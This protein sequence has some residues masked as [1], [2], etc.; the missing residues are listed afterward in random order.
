VIVLFS[1][2]AHGLQSNRG[3]LRVIFGLAGLL[4]L[5]GCVSSRDPQWQAS[6]AA[7]KQAAKEKRS[8]EAEAHWKQALAEAERSGPDNW[9][10]A[11]T[12]Q[13][14]ARFYES[15]GRTDEAEQAFRRTLAIQERIAPRSPAAARTL[16]DLA[17]LYHGAGRYSE[18]EP[19][20][21]RALPMAEAAFGP[22]HRNVD[23]I[24]FLLARLYTQQGR[25]AEA[26]ALYKLLL[27]AD[28][29]YPQVPRELAQV[30]ETLGR[31]AEAEPL[32]RRLVTSAEM[33]GSPRERARELGLLAGLL[34]RMGRPA[35]ASQ[36]EA[37][38]QEVF[39]Q[40]EVEVLAVT[41]PEVRRTLNGFTELEMTATVRYTLR[42]ADLARLQVSAVRFAS[43]GC[44]PGSTFR[45]DAGPL[46]P[47]TRGEGSRIIPVR[48]WMVGAGDLGS[49]TPGEGYVTVQSALW[50]ER[51]HRSRAVAWARDHCYTLGV[52]GSDQPGN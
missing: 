3:M 52:G 25:Y 49:Q 27:A 5:A 20:Y 12:L 9:R 10:V 38:A 44:L 8:A 15:Q 4:L 23:V 42:S 45:L 50:S 18:A 43:A 19:L 34:R 36:I 13:P 30:Y 35:E 14:M 11:S 41:S 1:R 21:Q 22:T 40:D 31:Y 24:R 32:R 47:I 33:A 26:E 6:L 28:T 39:P 16:T 17:H 29:S 7:A 51:P 48:W 2:V 46:L 37:R